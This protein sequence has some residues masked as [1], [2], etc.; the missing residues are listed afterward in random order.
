M[1][2]ELLRRLFGPRTPPV[3]DE[4]Q[5]PASTPKTPPPQPALTG[6]AAPTQPAQTTAQPAH[7]QQKAPPRASPS[8]SAAASA[9]PETLPAILRAPPPAVPV[10][11]PEKVEAPSS[12]SPTTL[13]PQQLRL[14]LRDARLTLRAP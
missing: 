4:V 1:L 8:V 2:I 5:Q 10:K 14:A 11:P 13:K 9:R 6:S 7:R 3:D 12:P